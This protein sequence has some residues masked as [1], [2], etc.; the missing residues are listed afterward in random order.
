LSLPG[1]EAAVPP[2]IGAAAPPT[3]RTRSGGRRAAPLNPSTSCSTASSRGGSTAAYRGLLRLQKGD[4]PDATVEH[5]AEVLR[6]MCGALDSHGRLAGH[7]ELAQLGWPGAAPDYLV[8]HLSSRMH[9]TRRRSEPRWP[10]AERRTDL[11]QHCR[12]RVKG[13]ARASGSEG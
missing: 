11:A 5:L 13:G 8:R 6:L 2:L 3:W 9:A 10:P 7:R 12:V 1:Q 4:A